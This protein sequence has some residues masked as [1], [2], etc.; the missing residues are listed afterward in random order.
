MSQVGIGK[1]GSVNYHITTNGTA[2]RDAESR[3]RQNRNVTKLHSMRPKLHTRCDRSPGTDRILETI[4]Y[5]WFGLVKESAF[6]YSA[7]ADDQGN[8]IHTVS[9]V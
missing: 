8:N 1:N 5:D 2:C 3:K 7:R 9:K 6:Q 4:S